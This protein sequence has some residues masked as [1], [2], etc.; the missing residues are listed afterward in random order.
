MPPFVPKLYADDLKAYNS[1]TND[2]AGNSFNDMLN[3]ITE[4]AEN[5]QLPISTD[6]SKWLYLS[7]KHGSKNRTAGENDFKLANV[8]L[9]EE[10]EVL[11]LGVNFNSKLDFSEHISSIIAKAKQRLSLLKKIFVSKN[12]SILILGFTTY[13]IPLLEFLKPPPKYGIRKVI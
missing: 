8:G 1:H 13:V 3:N 7:N 10:K 11:D 2:I 9:P 5:W 12:S 4:W 6:K